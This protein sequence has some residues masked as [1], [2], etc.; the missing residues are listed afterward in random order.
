MKKD[1]EEFVESLLASMEEG[2]TYSRTKFTRLAKRVN[3][4]I[5]TSRKTIVQ[6]INANLGL[7]D[8]QAKLNRKLRERGLYLKSSNYYSEFTVLGGVDA[9][10][11]AIRYKKEGANKVHA[12]IELERGVRQ[13]QLEF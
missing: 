7:V 5:N 13:L 11:E 4:K 8:V 12:G 1:T 10:K 6:Q 2:T 9:Q 3:S